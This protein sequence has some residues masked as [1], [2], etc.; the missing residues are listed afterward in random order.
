MT[1]QKSFFEILSL[2]LRST[3]PVCG[4]GP[5]F[6][7]IT[8]A[9]KAREFFLP[10]K[11]CKHCGFLF[12][13]EPG[14]YFG[15][16]TPLLPMMSLGVGLVFAGATY[17]LLETDLSGVLAGGAVGIVL[18]FFGF[19]RTSIAIYIALDHAIDPPASS[20]AVGSVPLDSLLQS[21]DED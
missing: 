9:R 14:Y 4:S 18:G 16:L 12:G 6:K 10:L 17:G 20:V 2:C 19:F 13:R 5:L 3:C 1:G 7:A 15:V 21:I 11:S 8:K